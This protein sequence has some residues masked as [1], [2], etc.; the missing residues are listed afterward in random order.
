MWTCR[1]GDMFILL[2]FYAYKLHVNTKE[3]CVGI[4]CWNQPIKILFCPFIFLLYVEHIEFLLFRFTCHTLDVYYMCLNE[5]IFSNVL[6]SILEV[7]SFVSQWT[8]Y[9]K[10]CW[11]HS[12]ETSMGGWPRI[13]TGSFILRSIR[14]K[15]RNLDYFPVS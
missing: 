12:D 5:N 4:A 14:E 1:S 13:G 10:C 6:F 8:G 15:T 7:N 11:I 9:F 2:I 3:R